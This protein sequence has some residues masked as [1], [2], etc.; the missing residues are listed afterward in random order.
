[1][2]PERRQQLMREAADDLR[3]R[4]GDVEPSALQTLA[5]DLRTQMVESGGISAKDIASALADPS[6]VQ[7]LFPAGG[8]EKETA[9]AADRQRDIDLER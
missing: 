6:L 9:S 7:S 8:V 5:D 4:W 1:M 2:T 3:S